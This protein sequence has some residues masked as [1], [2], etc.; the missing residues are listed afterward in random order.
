MVSVKSG[1]LTAK[2]GVMSRVF[3]VSKVKSI[4]ILGRG[5]NDTI[6]V[7]KGVVACKID[8]GDGNDTIRAGNGNDNILG[9]AGNDTI[10]CR[11]G[12]RDTVDGG[13]GTNSAQVDKIDV[14]KHIQK[15]LK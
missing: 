13:T 6:T 4:N 9:G 8:G 5:G 7:G 2:V 15:I 3:A 1:N 10:Y 11:N 14:L 12:V